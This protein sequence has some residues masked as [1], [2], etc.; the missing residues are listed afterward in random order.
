MKP[1]PL[2]T[3]YHSRYRTDKTQNIKQ[4]G[5]IMTQLWWQ[6]AVVYQIYPRSFM[7]SN[8]DG[9]GDIPGI[10]SKLDYLAALGVDVLWLS[11]VFRSPMDDN[12]YDISD[13]EDIAPEF[14]SLADMDALII[15]ARERGIRILLDLVVNHSSDEH[16]WFE[17]A[18]QSKASCYRDF[19]IWRPAAAD[20]GPPNQLKSYF[21]GSAWEWDEQSGEYYLHLFS[22]KQPDLNWQNPELRQTVYAMMNRWLDKGIGGFR[23]DVIDLIGKD[24]DRCVT[25]NGPDLHP[26]LQEMHRATLAGRDVLTVGESWSATPQTAPLYSRP[27]RQELSMVFQF[28]HITLTHHPEEGKWRPRP[29]DLTELKDVLAKWQSAMEGQ[30]WNSLFWANH[31]LPR[32]VSIYGNDGEYRVKSAKMLATTLH[33]MQGTPYIYQGEEIGMTNVQFER[34]DDYRDIETRNLYN[35]K[36]QQGYSHDDMMNAIHRNSRDNARTPMQWND[37]PNAG[38]SSCKPWLGVNPNFVDINVER[39]LKQADSIFDHYRRLINLRRHHPILTA[40]QFELILPDHPAIFAYTRILDN[41][42]WVIVSNFSCEPQRVRIPQELQYQSVQCLISNGG[43]YS[44]FK[45]Y[46]ALLPY[47]SFIVRLKT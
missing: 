39:D 27:D 31:D 20:G 11:P 16:P 28:E 5:D 35:E 45:D 12:G 6:N 18:R 46:W 44:S 26:F 40:G 3:L 22:R 4:T 14:G 15:G 1:A 9:I 30:G 2:T 33:G 34:I 23:M 38:F 7:D 8:K 43:K 24:P 32:A 36:R 17:N 19:Y 10:I 41:E 37:S 47:D 25:A 13:Y 29:F 21:G 42:C